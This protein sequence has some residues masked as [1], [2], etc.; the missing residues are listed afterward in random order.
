M[1]VSTVR[2]PLPD[3][4]SV[5]SGGSLSASTLFPQSN[6]SNDIVVSGRAAALPSAVREFLQLYEHPEEVQPEEAFHYLSQSQAVST[7]TLYEA[8]K[9]FGK[10][11][12]FSDENDSYA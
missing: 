6:N 10:P 5:C 3:S 2:P 7:A 8:K 9:Y 4:I 1:A 11:S 12:F